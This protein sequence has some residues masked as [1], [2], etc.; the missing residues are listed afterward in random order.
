[1]LLSK[2]HSRSYTCNYVALLVVLLFLELYN[3][4]GWQLQEPYIREIVPISPYKTMPPE[5]IL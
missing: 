2:Y 3:Y 5:C 1:M 4:K